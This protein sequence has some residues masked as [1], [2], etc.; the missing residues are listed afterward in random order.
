MIRLIESPREAM[1]GLTPFIPTATKAAYINR[2]LTCGFDTIETGSFVSPKVIPQ[3]QDSLEVLQLLDLKNTPSKIMFLL[4]SKKGA[5]IVALQEQVDY[6]SYPHSI[7]PTFL[8]RN[9]KT[10]IESSL[11]NVAFLQEVATR[12]GKQLVVY[13]SMAF[14][15]PYGDAWNLEILEESVLRLKA[16]GVQ[17]IPFSNVSIEIDAPLIKKVYQYLIPKYPDI[18]LGLHLHT[19]H[20]DNADKLEAAYQS[21]CRRFDTVYSGLG[22]CPLADKDLMGNVSTQ[23]VVRYLEEKQIVSAVRLPSHHL[24]F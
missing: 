8:N 7:S 22:G 18:T 12:K 2:L 11:E 3:M 4:V 9:M 20:S 24:T 15:N 13:I 14:G 10:D 16:L 19:R 5:E 21:G 1:Q 6:L 23:E 17:I